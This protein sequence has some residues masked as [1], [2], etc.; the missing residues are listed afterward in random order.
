MKADGKHVDSLN[1]PEGRETV[2]VAFTSFAIA[3]GGWR[4]PVL[5]KTLL[6]KRP[7]IRELPDTTRQMVAN[8]L[9]QNPDWQRKPTKWLTFQKK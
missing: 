7:T 8:Y 9:Q 6:N 4:Y 5:R 2:S 3:G 1:L